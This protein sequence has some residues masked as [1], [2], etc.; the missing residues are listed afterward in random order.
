MWTSRHG[1]R[2][3]KSSNSNKAPSTPSLPSTPSTISIPGFSGEGRA[4]L[5][6]R[7]AD[8]RL[9]AGRRSKT[10]QRSGGASSRFLGARTAPLQPG[11]DGAL[12]RS[13]RSGGLGRRRRFSATRAPPPSNGCSSK[14]EAGTTP[15]SPSTTRVAFDDACRTF[16]ARVRRQFTD[17]AR[18]RWHDENTLLRLATATS[19]AP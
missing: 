14:R 19:G 3:W 13:E 1:P 2:A 17:L 10:R 8:L 7:R 9:H 11:R 15:R 12:D 4:R 5:G 18:V 6:R 16:A